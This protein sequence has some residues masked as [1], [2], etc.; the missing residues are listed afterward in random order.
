[1]PKTL[2]HVPNLQNRRLPGKGEWNVNTSTG[3]RTSGGWLPVC[4]VVGASACG[5]QVG[6]D[7][8][9]EP[10]L[11]LE[12]AVVLDSASAS[13]DVVPALLFEN[14]EGL[15]LVDAELRGEFPARVRIDVTEAPPAD[16]LFPVPEEDPS[17][18]VAIGKIVVVDRR[19]PLRVPRL[20]EEVGDYEGSEDGTSYTRSVR[21]CAPDGACLSRELSCRREPCELLTKTPDF[22]TDF[23]P[24]AF[25]GASSG[26][27]CGIGDCVTRNVHCANDEEC[28][29]E[30]R[31][32]ARAGLGRYDAASSSGEITR[33]DVISEGG[34]LSLERYEQLEQT[35]LGYYVVYLT[36]AVEVGQL[37]R[38][39]RGYHLVRVRELGVDALFANFQCFTE[40]R[41]TAVRD[42]NRDHDTEFVPFQVDDAAAESAIEGAFQALQA[43]CP[44]GL[45][46]EVVADPLSEWL[47]FS[48]GRELGTGP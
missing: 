45:D 21:K 43:E 15:V 1:V 20:R 13:R 25:P 6:E 44:P 38:L 32:C 29:S 26:I 30:Y 12:G 10:L 9:G 17:V 35:A 8:S 36:A 27:A 46:W 16:V 37:G 28:E 11:S 7:Y 19:H 3:G 2:A 41:I 33:C 14:D 5:A 39:G 22:E 4:C 31:H 47:T 34:D 18:R 48:I 23:D 42:Y 40:A 24:D